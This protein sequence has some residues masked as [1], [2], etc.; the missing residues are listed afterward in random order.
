MLNIS[1]LQRTTVDGEVFEHVYTDAEKEEVENRMKAEGITQQK[2]V[3]DFA[4]TCS[5][6]KVDI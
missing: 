4:K 2:A 3:R 1:K 5:W 6:T